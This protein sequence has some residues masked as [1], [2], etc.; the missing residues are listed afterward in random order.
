[1]KLE[2]GIDGNPVIDQLSE[3]GFVD[4]VFQVTRLVQEGSHY[5][6][7]LAASHKNQEVGMNVVLVTGIKG[8]FDSNMEL[9]EDRV[10]RCGA[11]FLRCGEESDRLVLA[12]SQLYGIDV[13]VG[14]MVESETFTVI[15]LH[16]GD[17][18]LW[19][20][21][22]KLKLFGRDSEPCDEDAYYESFLNVDLPQGVVCW[23][24]KDP[25]YREP[26]LRALI[27]D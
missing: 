14:Q 18:D 4:L 20:Q 15:A 26:L 17:L 21:C 3:E 10:Y 6:F 23:N 9:M 27:S 1:M 16:Q 5:R 13:P 12:V 24:E 2:R 11:R 8:G 7:R 25:A 22:V 19:N